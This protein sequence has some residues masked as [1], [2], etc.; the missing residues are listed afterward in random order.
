MH[1]FGIHLRCFATRALQQGVYQDNASTTVNTERG[2]E[3]IIWIKSSPSLPKRRVSVS[4][5]ADTTHEAGPEQRCGRPLVPLLSG[6]GRTHRDTRLTFSHSRSP[7]SESGLEEG[8]ICKC[9]YIRVCP[10][11]SARTLECDIFMTSLVHDERTHCENVRIRNEKP[12]YHHC[13]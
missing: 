5:T 9:T 7:Q 8:T 1:P 13:H 11:V 3:I 2:T 10:L 6:T 4:V 12:F